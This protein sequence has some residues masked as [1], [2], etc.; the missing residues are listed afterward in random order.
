MSSL[1]ALS[2]SRISDY[3]QCPLMFNLKYIEKAFPP[4][5]AS[6]SIHLVKGAAY[7]KQLEDYTYWKL[8]AR[9]L[10]TDFSPAVQ[11]AIPI[12]DKMVTNF[13]QVWPERQV[14]VG[15]NFEPTTW[16]NSDGN[17]EV[18]FRSIWDISGVNPGH[19]AIFDWKSGKVYDYE[20]ESGQLHLSA[21]MGN[22]I[23]G[24]DEVDIAYVYIEHKVIKPNPPL[25]L[26]Q[27]DFPHIKKHFQMIFDEVNE[28]KT[29]EPTPNKY[30]NY[31][32]ATPKQCRFS[33][34]AGM[35]LK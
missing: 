26:T 7:H 22:A 31:C 33:P 2:W 1:I 32:K 9:Q 8:G 3:K 24:V 12:V 4:E 30:C 17:P 29:W 16:F 11:Q 20:D 35:V 6:K 5:D 18:A 21:V 28:R 15:Y 27:Q 34:K 10:P 25:K 13:Q 14:A 23:Y 19:A